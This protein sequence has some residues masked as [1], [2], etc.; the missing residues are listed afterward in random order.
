MNLFTDVI[1]R[2]GDVPILQPHV[3]GV[4]QERQ[5]APRPQHPVSFLEE[6]RAVEPVSRRHGRHK[7]HLARSKR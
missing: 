2:V 5:A 4:A 6:L 7:V 1:E 3:H